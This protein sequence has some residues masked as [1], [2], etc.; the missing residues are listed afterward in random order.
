LILKDPDSPQFNG[1]QTEKEALK[2]FLKIINEL[3]RPNITE[4]EI[5]SLKLSG[6]YYEVPLT[7]A[8]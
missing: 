1:N 6:E 5:E 8:V 3:K 2:M 4:S 7:E